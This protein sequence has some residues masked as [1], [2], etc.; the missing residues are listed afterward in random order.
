MEEKKES[1]SKINHIATGIAGAI[2]GAGITA[3]AAALQNKKTQ[4]KVKKVLKAAGT[5]TMKYMDE[6]TNEAIKQTKTEAGKI[7]EG[8][9]DIKK[10]KAIKDI[11]EVKVKEAKEV[12]KETKKPL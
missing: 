3:A 2:I 10:V 6:L 8:I 11:K 7:K 5:K 4:E 12:K 1:S 9:K